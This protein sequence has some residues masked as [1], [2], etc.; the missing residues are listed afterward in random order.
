MGVRKRHKAL[1]SAKEYGSPTILKKLGAIKTYQKNKSPS[2]QT[3]YSNMKW[4]RKKY[5]GDLNLH[6]KTVVYSPKPLNKEF[7]FSKSLLYSLVKVLFR[8][9]IPLLVFNF[10]CFCFII[11]QNTICTIWFISTKRISS[12]FFKNFNNKSS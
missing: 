9:I 7:E 5:D 8:F 3:L 11:C 4:L 6:G 12:K 10:F 1:N 2:F